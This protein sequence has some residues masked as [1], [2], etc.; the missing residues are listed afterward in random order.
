MALIRSFTP[1]G[2]G[3]SGRV[4]GEV[5]CGWAIFNSHG[6]RYLQLETYGS[7]TRAIPG[8]VSQ[9]IQLDEDG[10]RELR[11]LIAQAFPTLET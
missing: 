10:A 8:K 5:G 4:H 2:A 11:R 1:I 3:A 7:P 9:T 6:R